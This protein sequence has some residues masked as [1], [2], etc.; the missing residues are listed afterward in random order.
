M[1]YSNIPPREIELYP[2]EFSDN[3]QLYPI[4]NSDDV[5]MKEREMRPSYEDDCAPMEKWQ[6]KEFPSCNKMH[7]IDLI[8]Q[9]DIKLFG[10]NGY[11]RNAWRVDYSCNKRNH[12]HIEGCIETVV[13]KMLKL[14][15]NFEDA[16]YEHDR[17]DAMAMER[18]T[19]SPHVINIFGACANSVL[20]EFAD[21]ERVGT[22]AD[23]T[24]KTPLARLKIARD[25]ASG[26]ADVHSIDGDE[27]ATLVHF[28]V[29]LANVV[30][31]G[32]RLK[33]NDFNIGVIMTRNE[34]SGKACGFPARYPNPQ[35]RS[36]EE[37]N[38]S[39][40]LSEKVDI[41]SFGHI[42]FRL[43]CLHEPWHKLEPGYTKGEEIRKHYVNEQVKKGVLPFIPKE[44]METK[45]AEVAVI[46]KAMLAC[47][48]YDPEKRPTARSIANFLDRGLEELSKHSFLRRPGNDHWG[49]FRLG[50]K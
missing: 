25:I 33:W 19:S 14:Q 20:T 50:K 35:W 8:M 16:H 22:L 21:G 6:T 27:Q 43:I 39:Q 12:T 26:L 48:T 29:N 7:E 30:S 36:P 37:A 46:R 11:W 42:L 40:Q 4:L 2:A 47:Y 45:D 1:K 38:E 18:L 32:G 24:K 31:I 10:T 9:E 5:G 41:F 28:D 34:T 13:L 15:H 23:K 44:V 49:S 17:V 3:T